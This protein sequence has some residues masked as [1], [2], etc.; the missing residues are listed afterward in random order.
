[1]FRKEKMGGIM[2]R[3]QLLGGAASLLG[4]MVSKT[5]AQP[6]APVPADMLDAASGPNTPQKTA[7]VEGSVVL[8]TGSNRGI[9]KGFVEVLLER[10]ARKVYA[11]A[12]KA[13]NLPAMVA[14]DPDR[15]VG[16]VLD[17]NDEAQRQAAAAQAKD[18]TW[19]I[20]NAGV[21]GSFTA[22]ERRML[23]ASSLDDARFVMQTNCWSPAELARLFTPIILD[24]G[25]GAI[26]NILSV[27]AWFCLPEY[28]S[29]SM[30]KASAAI[31]TAGLRAELDREPVMVSGVFT[32]GVKTRMS[33]PGY[34]GGITPVAHAHE[35]LDA[36]A[37]GDTDVF[38][39]A[40]SAAMKANIIKDPQGF[41]RG[42]IERFH[43]NPLEIAPF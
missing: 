39:G 40:G 28:T 24:N 18:V 26:T 16:L 30:S 5:R 20:N 41:E 22:E 19:L 6:V 1:M 14:L 9:G 29:Y 13:E 7:Q 27:G 35:V 37:R 11:T 2:K 17:V 34:K 31:M 43:T 33:P 36:M 21:P 3:R 25:G 23:S 8:V 42:V 32:G 38:A 4:A 10:G 12:R 15:V